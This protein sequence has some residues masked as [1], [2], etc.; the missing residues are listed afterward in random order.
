MLNKF[1]LGLAAAA[2][3][4]FAA[5]AHAQDDPEAP[6]TTYMI[7]YIKLKDGSGQRWSELE[8]KYFEPAAE[9]AGLPK[10]QVHWLVAGPWDIMMIF[11]MPRG[12]ASLDTHAS[13]ERK[14]FNEALAK[15]A[16]SE[17][18]AKKIT[19]ESDSLETESMQTFSHTHP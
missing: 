12:M 4:A 19:D 7:E 14:A 10:A 13:P 3:L 17:E 18:A 2:T 6:R 11:T 8:E 15:I 5:P 1:A 9:A 16:G